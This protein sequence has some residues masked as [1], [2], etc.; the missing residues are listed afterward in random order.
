MVCKL[1]KSLY[2]L[3]QAPRAWYAKIDEYFQTQ[4]FNNS[5]HDPNL[6]VKEF[7]DGGLLIIVLYIDVLIT[8]GHNMNQISD[9][10]LKLQDAFDMTDLGFLH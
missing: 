1:N 10:K 8:K 7:D 3:K 9:M 4:G 5:P 6:Y 2:G